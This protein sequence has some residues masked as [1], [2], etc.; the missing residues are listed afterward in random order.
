M[1]DRYDVVKLYTV[2]ETLKIWSRLNPTPDKA[3]LGDA[4]E[5]P[6]GS[7]KVGV[8]HLVAIDKY[9]RQTGR[10]YDWYYLMHCRDIEPIKTVERT[11]I[12]ESLPITRWLLNVIKSWRGSKE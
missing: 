4:I 12:W 7:G 5:L 11:S 9:P 2:Y 3:N 10:D 6:L 1:T 8:Y